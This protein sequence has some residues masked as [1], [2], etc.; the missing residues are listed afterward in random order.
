MTQTATISAEPWLLTDPLPTD[1][2]TKDTRTFADLHLK[3]YTGISQD[4]MKDVLYLEQLASSTSQRIDDLKPI[5]LLSPIKRGDKRAINK[6]FFSLVEDRKQVLGELNSETFARIQKVMFDA[7]EKRKQREIDDLN[8]YIAD[9][10]RSVAGRVN[11]LNEAVKNLREKYDRKL[12]LERQTPA[13]CMANF[14]AILKN[15]FFTFER[16]AYNTAYFVTTADVVM[17]QK[18]NALGVDKSV[19]FGRFRFSLDILNSKLHATQFENNLVCK[20][21]Y[22]HPYIDREG[23]IC[24]GT[25]GDSVNKWLAYREFGKIFDI[26]AALL[27]TFDSGSIPYIGLDIFIHEEAAGLTKRVSPKKCDDCGCP[28][29]DC[30][31]PFCG[32]CTEK[33]HYSADCPEK[34]KRCRD[35]GTMKDKCRCNENYCGDCDHYQSDCECSEEECSA[36]TNEH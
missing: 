6:L 33:G 15:P 8:Y 10:E 34:D 13:D 30:E 36:C 19:N 27:V 16:F 3:G 18:Q 2:L 9:A 5:E 20:S 24:F 7:S 28:E 31:C 4:M 32:T 35:C 17:R 29:A 1:G 12:M 14:Q 23:T 25:A 21:G 22:W 26:L 11:S